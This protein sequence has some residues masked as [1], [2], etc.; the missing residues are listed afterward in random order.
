MASVLLVTE[1]PSA[2]S[3][4]SLTERR[5]GHLATLYPELAAMWHPDNDL[6]PDQVRSSSPEKVKWRCPEGHVSRSTVVARVHRWRLGRAAGR[7]VVCRTCSSHA[8]IPMLSD[9]APDLRILWSA[10]NEIPFDEAK[11]RHKDRR[12]WVCE[13]GHEWTAYIHSLISLGSGCPYCAGQRVLL[14]VNDLASQRPDLL[15]RW[16][17][18]N[19]TDPS[20]VMTRSS[21]SFLWICSEGHTYSSSVDE[22]SRGRGCGVCAGQQVLAGV[23]DLASLHPEIAA[24]WSSKN[25]IGPDQVTAGSGRPFEW[26]CKRGH[27]WR[28]APRTRVRLGPEGG[29]RRCNSQNQSRVEL[30]LWSA[31]S[32]LLPHL[33]VDVSAPVRWAKRPHAQLDAAL[34]DSRVAFEYDGSFWHRDRIE[35]DREKTVALLAAGWNVIRIR[36][37]PLELLELSDPDFAEIAW[38][39]GS[40]DESLRRLA[41]NL[42]RL[43]TTGKLDQ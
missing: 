19:T 6:R 15:V 27:R 14:G 7:S 38:S 20:T 8:A 26:V 39:D 28:A 31:L 35:K 30:R 22:Q 21:R 1:K 5:V 37:Q 17:P 33:Q 4:S 16:S 2:A 9:A 24:T 34:V 32:A 11:A 41:A 13:L 43:I 10:S 18:D 40:S 12:I 42:C 3:R 25:P 29:C 23:N 36:E